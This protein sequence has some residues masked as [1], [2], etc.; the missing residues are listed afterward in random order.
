M[1]KSERELRLSTTA[2]CLLGLLGL[3]EWTTYELAEQMRRGV[4]DL[5]SAARSMV[6]AEPK[7]LVAK[8]LATVRHETTG[9]RPR[10]VYAITAEGREALRAWLESP[11][12]PPAMQ[13]EGI[14]K[15]LLAESDRLDAC[16]SSIA[17][18]RAWAQSVR[19]VGRAV[20]REYLAGRGPFQERVEQVALTFSLLWRV[21]GAVADWADWAAARLDDLEDGRPDR[22]VLQPFREAVGGR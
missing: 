7:Q 3:R 10:A 15:V 17:A 13:F 4:G 16:R 9:R 14:L 18:A 19:Q 1:I 21:T 12:A 2:Y 22:D 11:G 6:F 20:A 5:W 8:G